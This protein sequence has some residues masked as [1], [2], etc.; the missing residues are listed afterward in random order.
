MGEVSRASQFFN[1][2]VSASD[3]IAF[4]HRLTTSVPPTCETE[5][6]DF[7]QEPQSDD[8]LKRIWY[9][10]LSGFSNTAGGV[11]IWG[12]QARKDSG[13]VD[14]AHKITHVANPSTFRTRLVELHRDATD[15]PVQGVE[16][17]E[18]VDAS[19]HCKGFVVCLVPEGGFKPYRAEIRGHEQYYIRVGDSFRV[20][21]RA[22]LR[23]LFYPQIRSALKVEASLEWVLTESG[24]RQ[25]QAAFRCDLR[26]QNVGPATAKDAHIVFELN[27]RP[28]CIAAHNWN[29]EPHWETCPLP[30][31]QPASVEHYA[32]RARRALHP[33]VLYDLV[34]LTVVHTDPDCY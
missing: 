20:P 27:Q 8:E 13:G 26:I 32:M 22:L 19:A 31:K 18:W 14:A 1:D 30:Q 11:I 15:P 21:N 23:S 10:A 17:Q 34:T 4:L 9:P 28:R 16:I 5:F 2:I 6:L 12:I 33:G 3:Q 7:K 24:S 25:D 29:G